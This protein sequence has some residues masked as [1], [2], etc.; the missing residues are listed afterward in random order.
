M[1]DLIVMDFDGIE[2]ADIV[3]SKLRAL[4]K[5]HLID[6][7]DAVV[8]IRPE[9]GDVQI[10]QS[11]NLTALGASHGLSTGALLGGLVGLLLLNPLAGFAVGGAAGAAVGALTGRLS[12]FGINDDFI[13]DLG[14]TIKPGT[15]ALFVLVAKA[16]P[17]K[18]IAEIKEH[19]PRILKTSLS[20]SQEEKLRTA[21]ENDT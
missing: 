18:V 8:V 13:R 15:S 3:L 19:S 11:V 4:G 7:T 20:S 21:L 10:K 2:T 5:A 1:S 16:T 6:L 12:D 17:D 9:Q 14:K